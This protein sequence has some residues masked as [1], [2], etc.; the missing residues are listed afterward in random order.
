[1]SDKT[2]SFLH[3]G[4]GQEALAEAAG[5]FFGPAQGP[6]RLRRTCSRANCRPGRLRETVLHRAATLPACS[7][8]ATPRLLRGPGRG[9]R[10]LLGEAAAAAPLGHKAREW[11]MP[12]SWAWTGEGGVREAGHHRLRRGARPAGG[13]LHGRVF[14]DTMTG[15]K[16]ISREPGGHG[17]LVRPAHA[18][19]EGL[20]RAMARLGHPGLRQGPVPGPAGAGAPGGRARGRLAQG[21]DADLAMAGV[22]A[23]GGGPGPA[24]AARAG[25]G[26]P[27]HRPV[28][29]TALRA[30]PGGRARGA[31]RLVAKIVKSI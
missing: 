10:P 25:R 16:R 1:M 12:K 5:N 22:T 24:R 7:C 18:R 2:L 31:G 3:R 13:V 6:G 27:G 11:V 17:R 19:V 30:G 29:R 20:N 4:P 8:P 9:P 14:V 15:R 21:L 28:L 23:A 26:A